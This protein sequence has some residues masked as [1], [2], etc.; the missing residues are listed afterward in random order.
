MAQPPSFPF[1]AGDWIAGTATL[2]LEAK[3]AYIDLIAHQWNANEGVPG[4]DLVA[5]SRIIRGSK[6]DA[7]RL[8][9]MIA[10]K[11]VL[12]PD[13]TY[14]N[15]RVEHEREA[16]ARYYEAKR[17]NGEKGG[18]PRVTET[19]PHG[20]TGRVTEAKPTG[21]PPSPSLSVT[22]VTERASARPR[23]G[24]P[25]GQKTDV[26]AAAH[27][28]VGPEQI[29]SVPA[30]WATKACREYRLT[31]ADIETFAAWASK[32]VQREGFED[33]GKRLPWLDGLLARWR[34][35][36]AEDA[37]MAK[38]LERTRAFLAEQDAHQRAVLAEEAARRG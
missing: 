20:R 14:R 18:R 3:G 17:R 13:G 28:I 26:N 34:G 27:I 22:T 37:E 30:G 10:S 12:Q 7:K 11:F 31:L 9:P 8:W 35:S 24:D 4:D 23:L 5:L 32:V 16:K 33:G 15:A 2:S 1:Y 21:Y 36:R 29:V 19:P 25:F 38:A 6:S